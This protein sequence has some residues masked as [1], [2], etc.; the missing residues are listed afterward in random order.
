VSCAECLFMLRIRIVTVGT[1][2]VLA[3]APPLTAQEV[4]G[5][6][7]AAEVA[8]AVPPESLRRS[9]ASEAA[10]L[11]EGRGR[12]ASADVQSQPGRSSISRHPVLTGALVGAGGARC[13]PTSSP[14]VN[15]RVTRGSTWPSS[16]ESGRGLAPESG[17]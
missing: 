17:P 14:G 5:G 15:A 9:I 13:G 8:S 1:I 16:A 12:V 3:T 2:T 6:H 4:A 11:A 10:R 7:P